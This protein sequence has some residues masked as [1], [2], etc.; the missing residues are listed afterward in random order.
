MYWGKFKQLSILCSNYTFIFLN[1]S[2]IFQNI[3]FY[4]YLKIEKLLKL[5]FLFKKKE[6]YFLDIMKHCAKWEKGL[7][8]TQMTLCKVITK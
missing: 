4:V 5:L 3:G 2:A 6:T 8:R 1:M 7:E